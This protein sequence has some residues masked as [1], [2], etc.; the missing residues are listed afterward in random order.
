MPLSTIQQKTVY[1]I[2]TFI[3]FAFGVYAMTENLAAISLFAGLFAGFFLKK[4][5][6]LVKEKQKSKKNSFSE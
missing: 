2:L 6:T 3:F 4:S 5:W 1:G